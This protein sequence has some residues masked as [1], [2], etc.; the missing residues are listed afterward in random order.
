[1]KIHPDD[2]EPELIAF[3]VHLAGAIVGFIIYILF[4]RNL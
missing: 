2:Y 3:F 4:L 1:M